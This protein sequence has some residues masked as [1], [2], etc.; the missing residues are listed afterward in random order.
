MNN[1][2]RFSFNV[3]VTVSQRSVN[4][5][6]FEY[7][8]TRGYLIDQLL[9]NMHFLVTDAVFTSLYRLI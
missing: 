4:T 7:S 5:R 1:A 2:P 6:T 9:F 3:S 8:M